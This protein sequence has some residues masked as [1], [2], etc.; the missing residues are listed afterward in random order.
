MRDT[1]SIRHARLMDPLAVNLQQAARLLGLSDRT[2]RDLV[3][4]GELP[5]VQPGGPGG[6]HIVRVAMLS[7]W[8]AERETRRL[9][10]NSVMP[11]E[12]D[13][14]SKRAGAQNSLEPVNQ[15]NGVQ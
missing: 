5:T 11:T 9:P 2:V 8:L 15:G 1:L 13:S 12:Q 3:A 10:A 6:K 7:E 4:S 14:F